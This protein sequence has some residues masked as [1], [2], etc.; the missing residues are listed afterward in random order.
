MQNDLIVSK[1]VCLAN[2]SYLRDFFKTNKVP[3]LLETGVVEIKDNEVL[4]KDKSGNVSSIKADSVIV[5]IGYTP[6]PIANKSK[7]IHV[8]GDAK[9]VGNLRTV[10]WGAWDVC[11]KI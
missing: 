8:I 4:V 11:M 1:G 2:S 5:S 3:T 7:N 9:E 6:A 10:I